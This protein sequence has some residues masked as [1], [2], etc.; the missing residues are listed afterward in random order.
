MP[1]WQSLLRRRPRPP[2]DARARQ[3]RGQSLAIL[4]KLRAEGQDP[5][6][7]RTLEPFVDLGPE[8]LALGPV[9]ASLAMRVLFGMHTFQG[10]QRERF[11]A[12]LAVELISSSPTLRAMRREGLL[13]QGADGQVQETRHGRELFDRL[14][15]A[16]AFAEL[17]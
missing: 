1:D 17:L 8:V 15:Q 6:Y 16:G 2:T 9:P 4:A 3:V 7:L 12:G 11:L 13:A 10:G 14:R 5:A